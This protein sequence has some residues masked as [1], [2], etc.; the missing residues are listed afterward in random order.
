MRE[1]VLLLHR[2][3]VHVGAQADRTSAPR[4]AAGY[5]CDHARS[6]DSSVVLDAQRAQL[7]GDDLRRA[8]LVETELRMH[9]Q[10]APQRGELGVPA[11]DVLDR[12][13]HRLSVS[14]GRPKGLTSPSG[15][16]SEASIGGSI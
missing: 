1:A 11:L 10:V 14:P 7:L 3:R 6:S 15:E 13:R 12:I 4:V 5:D 8:V 16:V 2:Q 9:V